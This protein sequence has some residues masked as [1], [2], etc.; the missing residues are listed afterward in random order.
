MGVFHVSA[1]DLSDSLKTDHAF[2]A[3]VRLSVSIA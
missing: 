2:W 3:S 1:S